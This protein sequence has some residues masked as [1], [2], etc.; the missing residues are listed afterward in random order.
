MLTNGLQWGQFVPVNLDLHTMHHFSPISDDQLI[1]TGKLSYTKFKEKVS[2][3]LFGELPAFSGVAKGMYI[4]QSPPLLASILEN[5]C[6]KRDIE[7]P[8][9]VYKLDC[10]NL[11]EVNAEQTSFFP[12]V[13][14]NSYVVSY[15]EVRGVNDS[16]LNI[17]RTTE[18]LYMKKWVSQCA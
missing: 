7:N 16:D 10:H 11:C 15:C 8:G 4:L 2:G 18:Y 1:M 3:P 13:N 17:R 14:W 6:T 12:T 9:C 5:F